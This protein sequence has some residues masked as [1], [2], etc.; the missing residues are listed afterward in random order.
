MKMNADKI[1]EYIEGKGVTKIKFTGHGDME[2]VELTAG[3]SEPADE[4]TR[5]HLGRGMWWGRD[6]ANAINRRRRY[7]QKPDKWVE[8]GAP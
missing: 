6:L 8:G 5:R 7:P 4:N 1:I 3:I 2:W